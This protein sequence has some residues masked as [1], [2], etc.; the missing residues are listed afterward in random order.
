MG[1]LNEM[2]GVEKDWEFTD[3]GKL[4]FIDPSAASS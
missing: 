4:G 2:F 3:D 1:V